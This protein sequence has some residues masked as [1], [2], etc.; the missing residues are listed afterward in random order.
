MKEN[1]SLKDMPSFFCSLDALQS[2]LSLEYDEGCYENEFALDIIELPYTLLYTSDEENWSLSAFERMEMGFHDESSYDEKASLSVN[3]SDGNGT[4]S[5]QN[6]ILSENMA[7]FFQA[8]KNLSAFIEQNNIKEI[9]QNLNPDDSGIFLESENGELTYNYVS[10]KKRPNL[11]CSSLFGAPRMMR[12]YDEDFSKGLMME[13]MSLEDK[14]EAAEAGDLD[15]MRQ[16]ADIYL[17][18]SDEVEPDPEKTVYWYKKLA[19]EGE[20]IAMFNLGLHSAKGFGLERDYNQA[21]YWMDRAA[22][23]GDE[24]A[25]QL[26]KMYRAAEMNRVKAEEGDAQAQADF[27]KFLMGL[28]RSLDQ[29]GPGKDYSESVKWAK[30]AVAQG[31]LDGMYTLALAFGHGRGVEE[32]LLKAFRLYEK[33]ANQGH[34]PS[35]TNLGCMYGRGEGVEQDESVAMEWIKK[36]ATLNDPDAK[37]IL[38]I[39]DDDDNDVLDNIDINELVQSVENGDK[40]AIM[41]YAMACLIGSKHLDKNVEKGIELLTK[42]GEDGK[43]EAYTILGTYLHNNSETEEDAVKAVYCFEKINSFVKADAELA[44]ELAYCYTWGT[45]NFLDIDLAIY[46]MAVSA[47]LGNPKSRNMYRN[48]LYFK[49][50]YEAM[51]YDSPFAMFLSTMENAGYLSEALSDTNYEPTDMI[52]DELFDRFCKL[53]PQ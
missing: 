16:L 1:K 35:M 39:K 36:A 17:N 2:L 42:L 46:W 3:K 45:E 43:P 9:I 38:G 33:A 19:D 6:K 7:A 40:D 8:C 23:A 24:D 44:L 51:G 11:M 37:R 41:S 27:A 4:G 13:F 49:E 10:G 52:H 53:H 28:G 15:F 25:P 26:A 32:D 14:I 12:P 47:S 34:A 18:G 5:A 29:A 31:N 22:E 50:N 48:M 30:A 21:A 20:S